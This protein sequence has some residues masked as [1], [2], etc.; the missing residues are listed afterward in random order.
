MEPTGGIEV[1]QFTGDVLDGYLE[2]M[3]AL[4]R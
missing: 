4:T 3:S 2:I 1:E